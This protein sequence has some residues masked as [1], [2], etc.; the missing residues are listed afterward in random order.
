VGVHEVSFLWVLGERE[1]SVRQWWR[2]ES[3]GKKEKLS[4]ADEP[5]AER[6]SVPLEISMRFM[7]RKEVLA[8]QKKNVYWGANDV[9]G[10]GSKIY[11]IGNRGIIRRGRNRAGGSDRTKQEVR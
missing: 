5:L 1:S 4:K 9:M 11:A 2:V 10:V 6:R 7:N 3:G 8:F